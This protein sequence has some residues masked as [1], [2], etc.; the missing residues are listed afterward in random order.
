MAEP[1]SKERLKTSAM[2]LALI[3]IKQT[4]FERGI[5]W[6]D[7]V[8]H[9]SLN[10]QFFEVHCQINHEKNKRQ[11]SAVA[12]GGLADGGVLRCFR[13]GALNRGVARSCSVPGEFSVL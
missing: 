1:S 7:Q 8:P 12:P 4:S 13:A 3:W 10:D 11:K 5:S 2:R 9:N 6:L